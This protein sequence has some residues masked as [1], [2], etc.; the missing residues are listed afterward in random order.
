MTQFQFD[1]F[2]STNYLTPGAPVRGDA[3]ADHLLL[4]NEVSPGQFRVVG[5]TISSSALT[6][7][8]LAYIPFIINSNAPDHDELLTLGSVVLTDTNAFFVPVTVNSNATLSITVPPRFTAL[9]P[10][11]AGAIHLEL[12]GTVGRTYVIQ[13]ATNLTM[14]KWT[15]LITNTNLTGVLPFDDISAGNYPIRF[16]RAA[17]DH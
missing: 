3:L 4:T 10:T 2:D 13:A 14:P 5:F 12:T 15:P 1:L 8:V 7:G 9:F 6:S 11:N 16:Y 17:F